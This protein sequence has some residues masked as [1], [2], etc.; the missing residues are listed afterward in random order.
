MFSQHTYGRL[1]LVQ[2]RRRQRQWWRRRRR[3]RILRVMLQICQ[4]YGK[5]EGL[6]SLPDV[7]RLGSAGASFGYFSKVRNTFTNPLSDDVFGFR[8]LMAWQRQKHGMAWLGMARRQIGIPCT[9][10]RSPAP[11]WTPHVREPS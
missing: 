4:Y 1:V 9:Y 6:L 11:S 5:F 10:T 3:R 7:R 8:R 2:R